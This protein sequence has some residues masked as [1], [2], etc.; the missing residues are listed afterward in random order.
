MNEVT[1]QITAPKTVE[2]DRKI[3]KIQL[4]EVETQIQE[5]PEPVLP[6]LIAGGSV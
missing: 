6:S 3:Q 4:T 1:R 5:S 2:T